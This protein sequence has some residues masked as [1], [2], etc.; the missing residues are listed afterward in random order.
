MTLKDKVL[1]DLAVGQSTADA[2]A[3]R[4]KRTQLGVEKS[5]QKLMDENKVIPVKIMGGA[6]TV[7]RIVRCA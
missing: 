1:A 3:K 4:L 7:Y 2:I 5:L 6:L